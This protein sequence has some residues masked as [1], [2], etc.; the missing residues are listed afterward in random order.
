M[1]CRAKFHVDQPICISHEECLVVFVT[2]QNLVGLDA[3]IL[4]I[5]MF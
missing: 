5:C 3:V 2:V 4:M 1:H